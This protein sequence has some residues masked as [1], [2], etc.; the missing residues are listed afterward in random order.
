MLAVT[1]PR[2]HLSRANVAATCG[3]CHAGATRRFAGYLTHAT[4]HDPKKYPFVFYTFWGMTALLLG[5]FVVG[6]MHTLLWLP[7]AF[8]MRRE[9]RAAEEKPAATHETP[10][11]DKG[12]GEHRCLG[13][14]LRS[15]SSSGSPG[16]S[17]FCT[18]A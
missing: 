9:L 10:A 4:H 2:S 1:D 11:R 13:A 5:T 16:C 6:G 8:Q 17:G 7:R 14:K 15:A 12:E 3:K 18:S